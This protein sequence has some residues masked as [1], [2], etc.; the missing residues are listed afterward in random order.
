MASRNELQIPLTSVVTD[1]TPPVPPFGT[2]YEE[3]SPTYGYATYRFVKA[4]DA[5]TY[6]RGQSVA[7]ADKYGLMVSNDRA[8][9]TSLTGNR[10]AG[11]VMAVATVGTGVWIQRKGYCSFVLMNTDDDAAIGDT[12]ILDVAVDGKSNTV[13]AGTT[14][15]EQHQMGRVVVAVVGA[16]DIVEAVLDCP[17]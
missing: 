5:V 14:A 7:W 9:G 11:I 6:V 10:P 15:Y 17:L 2:E 4:L 12:L 3:F 8:G 13:A 1:I 16:T